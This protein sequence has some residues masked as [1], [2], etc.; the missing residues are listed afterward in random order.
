MIFCTLF[1]TAYLPQG[2]ALYRSLER[3]AKADFV[4]YVLCMDDFTASALRAANLPNLRIIPLAK[5]EDDRL[6]AV[7]AGR[8]VGEYC[9]TCTTS[10]ILHIQDRHGPGDVVTYVDADIRFFSD[11]AAI[12]HELGKG[13][14]FIHQ[15]NFAPKYAHLLP[16]AGRFNVGVAAFRNDVEGRACLQ[17]WKDQCL[18]ECSMDP[19]AGK[20]GDQN[21][22]DEWP[23]RY[24]GLVIS[25]NPGI[26][27]APW[28]ITA[29]RLERC[30]GADFVDGRPIVFYHYHG[31]RMLQPRAWF[32]SVFMARGDYFFSAEVVQRIYRPYA[33]ELWRALSDLGRTGHSIE[34]QLTP[35]PAA[36][37]EIDF[38]QLIFSIFGLP[39]PI[40]R[41]GRV[42]RTLYGIE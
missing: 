3:T 40:Q 42:V 9:W 17:R 37:A 30:D 2:I 8:S 11:P 39:L 5:I 12:L 32:K 4:L 27:P 23:Q 13:S 18:D 35:L 7:K 34:K 25:G 41:N 20:C 21:Y 6:R 14:I 38:R 36:R 1:N 24:P 15:H 28:N 22:L 26:G 31:L 10:L 16:I 33:R 19:A 29:A